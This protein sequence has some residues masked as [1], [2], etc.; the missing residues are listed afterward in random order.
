MLCHPFRGK[1]KLPWSKTV[2]LI[3][4]RSEGWVNIPQQ[5]FAQTKKEKSS[6]QEKQ[7]SFN[8]QT[9]NYSAIDPV[10]SSEGNTYNLNY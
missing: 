10:V 4:G 2:T 7:D 5:K 1:F 6:E 9:L 3:Y 8:R